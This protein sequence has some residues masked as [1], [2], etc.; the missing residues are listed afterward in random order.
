MYAMYMYVH[1]SYVN[2]HVDEMQHVFV[3]TH[4]HVCTNKLHVHVYIYTCNY[5]YILFSMY[6][7]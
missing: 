4:V 6:F 1:G 5:V 3:C 7:I 2:V